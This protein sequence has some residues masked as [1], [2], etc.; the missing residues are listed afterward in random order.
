MKKQIKE[1]VTRWEVM[2]IIKKWKKNKSM[3][4]GC[5]AIFEEVIS[6]GLMKM[7]HKWHIK[8]QKDR[9]EKAGLEALGGKCPR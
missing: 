8:A 3:E 7:T 9:G 1:N 4:V 5:T 6:V 2:K